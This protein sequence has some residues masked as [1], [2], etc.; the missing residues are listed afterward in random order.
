MRVRTKR[1]LVAIA[2]ALTQVVASAPVAAVAP[3]G[4][5]SSVGVATA[6]TPGFSA[7]TLD[8]YDETGVIDW[9]VPPVIVAYPD[10]P[11]PGATPCATVIAT[12]LDFDWGRGSP[13]AGCPEDDFSIYGTGTI[14][15]PYTGTVEFCTSND[16][17]FYIEIGGTFAIGDWGLHG[18]NPCDEWES[19]NNEGD[20][21][22]VAGQ[23]YP[24][25]V[26]FYENEAGAVL[27]LSWRWDGGTWT[28]VPGPPTTVTVS[29]AGQPGRVTSSDGVIDCVW[30]G[31]VTAGTCTDTTSATVVL[32]AT[33]DNAAD[34]IA[35]G[36]GC[37]VGFGPEC[38]PSLSL[39][40]AAIDVTFSPPCG[41][42]G[43]LVPNCG[44]ELRDD[45]DE[46]ATWDV[47]GYPG[48]EEEEWGGTV[49]T[50]RY[51]LRLDGDAVSQTFDLTAGDA[52]AVT[53]HLRRDRWADPW[54]RFDA[55]L[56]TGGT[57]TTRVTVSGTTADWTAAT[58][59]F[60]ADGPTATISFGGRWGGWYLDDVSLLHL[61]ASPDR[62]LTVEPP[63]GGSI[64]SGD[65]SID[66]GGACSAELPLGTTVDLVATPDEGY[67]F[68]SWTG[69]CTGTSP[70]CQVDLSASRRV[71]ARFTPTGEPFV[72]LKTLSLSFYDEYAARNADPFGAIV[73][74]PTAPSAG[75]AT[76][77]AA[78]FARLEFDWRKGS[79]GGTCPTDYFTAYGSGTLIAPY[80]GIVDICTSNDDGMFVE[81][82]AG[83]IVG[84]WGVHGADECNNEA[85]MAMV[86]GHA[87]PIR[88]WYYERTDGAVMRLR[89]RWDGGDWAPVPGRATTVVVAPSGTPGRVTS[90]NGVIDCAWDG[91][92]T[93]GTCA[94]TTTGSIE[95]TGSGE[96]AADE[97]AWAGACEGTT[98]DTCTPIPGFPEASA[99]IVFSP[100]C[101]IVGNLI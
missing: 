16:D 14:V 48:F 78:E 100:P 41:V 75:A 27:G 94:D 46:L 67:E 84:D 26:W 2:I 58:F 4:P 69:A 15:A 55:T 54:S 22:M 36:A 90:S 76:C 52:Y 39:A 23:S 49:R 28:R 91:E 34:E 20:L 7:L 89:W 92:T 97:L 59:E 99:G 9:D 62:V 25:R 72:G 60:T 63:G 85:S 24:V 33:G 31:E 5:G 44:F 70:A 65:G 77:H 71:G 10:A 64:S 17:G 88:V 11:A 81:V 30:D 6:P 87:Y 61:G 79:P 73:R 80:T 32:T 40:T 101:G 29:P 47:S 37:D 8:I 50:G 68:S 21:A 93:S 43:N 57:T 19:G 66:C 82:G 98:T 35:W 38:T 3:P 13:A 1:A 45:N 74:Y 86:E 51:A 18:A 56:T 96:G 83:L 12:R 53:A 95:L 42:L